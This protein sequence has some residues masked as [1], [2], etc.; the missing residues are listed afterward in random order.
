MADGS[1]S[2]F[3]A[4]LARKKAR[5][6]KA[7]GKFDRKKLGFKSSDSN[8]EYNFPKLPDHELEQVKKTI[9]DKIRSERRNELI[10]IGIILI[11]F[12]CFLAYIN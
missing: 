5:K 3:K 11:G 2:Q 7:Q 8:Q 12:I 4:T 1:L 9:R 10:L 6:D